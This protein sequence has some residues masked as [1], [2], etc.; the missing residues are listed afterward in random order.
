M[1]ICMMVSKDAYERDPTGIELV[2]DYPGW[3]KENGPL[4]MKTTHVGVVLSL[5]EY[6]GYDDSDFYA[7]VWD[8]EKGEAKRVEYATTRGWTYPNNAWPDATPEVLAAYEAWRLVQIAKYNEQKRLEEIQRVRVGKDAE[9][10]RGRKVPHGTRGRVF[11]MGNN[12]YGMS[13]GIE[14]V[15]GARFF[16]ALTNLVG[17]V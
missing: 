6:N 10:V 9:V 8:A 3:P 11:W 12:G 16:T 4:Y 7:V 14:T 17:V 15:Q 13:A 5:G 2:T 1:A